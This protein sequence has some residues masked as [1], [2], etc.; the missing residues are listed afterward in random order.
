MALGDAGSWGL[1]PEN[2]W[3]TPVQAGGLSALLSLGS[4]RSRTGH[5]CLD[6]LK[7]RPNRLE[8]THER[9]A[10]VKTL[11]DATDCEEACPFWCFMSVRD[12]TAQKAAGGA[13]L[14]TLLHHHGQEVLLLG[15]FWV[16]MM[17]I[18]YLL[19]FLAM[20]IG[21]LLF[22]QYIERFLKSLKP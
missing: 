18:S 6:V 12:S 19:M 17:V 13:L 1:F 20:L 8:S 14:A 10:A 4:P 5:P 16:A 7:L 15:D 11:E 21:E 22:N 3:R 2:S 9:R